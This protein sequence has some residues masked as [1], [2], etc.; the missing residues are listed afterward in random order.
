M[1]K[2][3]KVMAAGSVMNEPSNG[4]KAKVVKAKAMGRGKGNARTIMFTKP[5]A[6][7]KIGRLP[8]TTMMAN[9]NMGSVK[10]RELR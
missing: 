7:C 4:T 8:A 6:S 10:L 3:A 2:A 5:A 1:S 9:T